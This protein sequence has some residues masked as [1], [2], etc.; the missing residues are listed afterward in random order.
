MTI[1]RR[2]ILILSITLAFGQNISQHASAQD[3]TPSIAELWNLVQKQQATID[4]LETEVA[5]VQIERLD[6]DE[7]IESIADAIEPEANSGHGSNSLGD[8]SLGGYGELHYEGGQKDEI[9]FHRFVLFVGHEFTDSIRFFSEIEL[10]HALAGDNAPGAVELEQA[11]IEM[12][13]NNNTQVFGGVHLVPVGFIN[14]THEPTTFYGVERNAIESNIIPTTWWEGGIGLRG[15]IGSSGFSYDVVASSGLNLNGSNDYNIRAGRQKISEAKL[16]SGAYTGRIQY[17]GVPGVSLASSIFYQ[18]DVTQGIG[19]AF[20]GEDV[21][22]LLWTTN[23]EAKYRGLALRALYAGWSLNGADVEL[24]GRDAQNG[25]FIEPS[26]QFDLPSGIIEDG[27]LGVFY[28]YSEWDNNAGLNNNTAQ[29][30]DVFGINFWPVPDV[31]LKLDYTNEK[32][33]NNDTILRA[34]NTWLTILL[35]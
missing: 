18:P 10:E 5:S 11:F 33:K 32:P 16:S 7:K 2:K 17:T 12:D 4:R 31:V 28:R 3:S 25:F 6:L 8:L 30:R 19:D 13:L 22:A 26:Y 9:D 20:T 15:N 14:E 35:S 34:T 21:D 23:L 24:S 1:K 29:N 27:K